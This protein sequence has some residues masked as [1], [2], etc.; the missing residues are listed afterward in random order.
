V[1]LKDCQR[2]LEGG[3]Q[4]I[5]FG[6]THTSGDALPLLLDNPATLAHVTSRRR[7]IVIRAAHASALL[8]QFFENHIT[9]VDVLR[10][11]LVEYL[12]QTF[13]LRNVVAFS[14]ERGDALLLFRNMSFAVGHPTFDLLKVPQVHCSIAH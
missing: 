1:V 4:F 2:L 7:D 5:R 12:K 3:D 11:R 10:L 13:G 14:P 6:A 8:I 9:V